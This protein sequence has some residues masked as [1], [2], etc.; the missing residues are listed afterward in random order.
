MACVCRPLLRVAQRRTRGPDPGGPSGRA[1]PRTVAAPA[2]PA[3]EAASARSAAACA[4]GSRTCARGLEQNAVIAKQS[5]A[6]EGDEVLH[7]S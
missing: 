7:V 1:L 3:R 2:V 6:R 4:S 5:Q